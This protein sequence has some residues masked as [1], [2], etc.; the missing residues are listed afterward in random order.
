MQ[1]K[2]LKTAASAF[3][4]H[5]QRRIL[6]I[7]VGFKLLELHKKDQQQPPQRLKKHTKTKHSRNGSLE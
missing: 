5:T 7:V 1:L 3:K 2:A 6:Q 4:Q